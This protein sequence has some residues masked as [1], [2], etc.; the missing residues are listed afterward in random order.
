MIRRSAFF[1]IGWL[2][3]FPTATVLARGPQL[4]Q[5][6]L[7][8]SSA[9]YSLVCTTLTPAPNSLGTG[10]P[11]T[12]KEQKSTVGRTTSRQPHP[13]K[14]RYVAEEVA[15]QRAWMY[16]A[17]LPGLG[18]AYNEQYWRI[19]V[20][21]AVFTGIGWGAIYNHQEYT[22][23]KR[24]L[25]E[26]KNSSG[27]RNYV[28]ACRRNRDIFLILG[29]FWYTANIFDAYV[30]ASLKTFNLSDDISLEVQPNVA[31]TI[32]HPPEIGL[33]LTLNFKK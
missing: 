33:H 28:D 2:Y 13:P 10:P 25:L 32:G 18:Q 21:Y 3:F 15:M 22:R 4:K 6:P 27:L 7:H 1:L 20:I 12:A 9:V 23:S 24:E 5:S 31:P 16:S 17:V 29:V 11:N 30:G 19:P 8:S 14:R 26:G